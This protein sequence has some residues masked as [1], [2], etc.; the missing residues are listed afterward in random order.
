MVDLRARWLRLP[1]GNL[2]RMLAALPLALLVSACDTPP[3]KPPAPEPKAAVVAPAAPSPEKVAERARRAALRELVAL[4]DRLYRVTAPLLIN[5][6]ALCP[7]PHNLLGFSAKNK[8]S[9]PTDFIDGAQQD[10][11]LD[12]QLQ[13]TGVMPGS[14]AAKAGVQVG[15]KLVAINGVAIPAGDNAEHRAS[16]ELANIVRKRN[17]VNLMID[18]KGA[19]ISLNVPLTRACAYVVDLGNTER[20]GAYADGRHVLVTRGML[21]AAAG[22]DE[23]AYVLATEMARNALRQSDKLHT[24]DVAAQIIDNLTQ[25]HPDPAKLPNAATPKLSTPELDIAAD[26][27]GLYMAARAG[28]EVDRAGRFVERL[29]IDYPSADADSYTAIHPIG[30]ER[31]AAIARTVGEIKAKQAGNKPLTP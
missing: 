21:K 9:Y 14:G 4:Q 18:R 20:V 12:E 11:G 28:F 15:D 22:D 10:L 23:L 16:M 25:L 13:V 24:T 30:D 6:S 5:N 31:L 26:R 7:N 8:Y 1:H 19:S 27:R 2:R 29:A 17:V 3:T